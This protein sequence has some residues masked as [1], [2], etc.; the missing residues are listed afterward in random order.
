MI[1]RARVKRNFMC[2]FADRI[3]Y[4]GSRDNVKGT[5]LMTADESIKT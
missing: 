1:E 3:S 2:G 4:I 5:Y